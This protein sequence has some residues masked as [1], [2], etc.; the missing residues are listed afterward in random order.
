MTRALTVV[1]AGLLTTVQDLGRWGHQASGVPVAGAMDTR[2]LR[3]A[4]LLVGNDEGAAALEITL[5]GPTLRATGAVTAALAGAAL[6]VDV[7]GRPATVGR[8]FDVA[9]GGVIRIGAGPAGAGARAYLAVRGGLET[10]VV[11]GS[12]ATHLVARLG[13]LGGRAL[14]TGDVLP[15]GPARGRPTTPGHGDAGGRTG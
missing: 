14:M 13:G 15:L 6:D 9:D 11:L 3:Q 2:A 4:N 5:L 7:D 8:V 1:R 12:R 10:P